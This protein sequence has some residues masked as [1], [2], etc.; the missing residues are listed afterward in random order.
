MFSLVACEDCLEVCFVA[1]VVKRICVWCLVIVAIFMVWEML[2]SHQLGVKM[3]VTKGG[4]FHR[5]SR[6]SLCNTAILWNFIAYGLYTVKG[7]IMYF[8]HYTAVALCVWD[9][10][11]QKC[12]SKC[13]NDINTE[14]A[15]PEEFS[16]FLL[17]PWKF[18][19]LNPPL[20][21]PLF[22]FFYYSVCIVI[23]TTILLIKASLPT[24][25]HKNS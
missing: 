14:W 1:L 19:I 4:S 2:K 3:Q 16:S 10:Q 24:Q 23:F 25:P 9:W 22:A 15:I 5:E 18:H 17:Y 12:N 21:P 13:P 7:F 11:S 20:L 8:F 6:F